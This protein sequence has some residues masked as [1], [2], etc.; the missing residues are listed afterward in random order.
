MI[1][2][3]SNKRIKW[4]RA[5]QNKRRTREREQAYVIEGTR[6]VREAIAADHPVDLILYT[7]NLDDRGQEL[8]EKMAHLGG[9]RML[10]SEAVMA[11]CS[12]TQSPPGLLAVLP[13]RTILKP[14]SENLAL[15]IDHLAD[16]GNLGTLLRTALAA[17]VET[18]YLSEGTVDPYNPKVIR[19]AMGAHMRLPILV[20]DAKMLQRHLAGLDVWLAEAHAGKPYT[21][22]DWR[23]PVA[24]IIGGEAHGPQPAVRAMADGQ[25]HIPMPGG[26][27]SLNAAMAAAVILFEI[28]RQR[29][30]A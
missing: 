11:S 5:L 17:G 30:E 26:A 6:L 27:E 20:T 7:D 2:S 22:V 3:T 16:P 28:V 23:Q 4:I 15:V 18:V 29:G 8:V 12:D 14:K 21:E 1:T 10:V 19:G 9:E 25:V 24:L 13:I